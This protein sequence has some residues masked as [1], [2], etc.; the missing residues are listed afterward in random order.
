MPVIRGFSRWQ[1]YSAVCLYVSV[2][3]TAYAYGVYSNLL[4]LN[5][6]FSQ[7][8]LD[9]VASVGNTGLYLSLIAGLILDNFGLQAVVCGGGFLI[10]IGFVYIW[11]AVE[12]LVPADIYSISIFFF[13]SQFGVCC[14]VSSSVTFAVRLFPSESR[15]VSVGLTKGYYGLSSAVLGDFA[16]GYFGNAPTSFL[17]FIAIFIPT[18]G[19]CSS[20]F[21][22]LLPAH[23]VN[24][25]KEEY[26]SLAP[27]IAHWAFLFITLLTIGLLQFLLVLPDFVTSIT[28]VALTCTIFAVCLLPSLYGPRIV[29]FSSTPPLKIPP[30]AAEHGGDTSDNFHREGGESDAV[31]TCF[32]GEGIP[33][34]KAVFVWR[35]WAMYAIFFVL[36]GV[37]LMVI[38]N[39]NAIAVSA[40]KY[41]S[42]FFVT[43]IA[44]ANGLG[45]VTAGFIS[46]IAVNYISK[47]ELLSVVALA[48]AVTQGLHSMGSATLLYPC[49]LTVGFLFGCTVSLMAVNIADIFG[50]S[51]IATNFGAIDSAAMVGTLVFAAGIV[52]VYYEES[53]GD[54][55]YATSA[56]YETNCFRVPFIINSVCCL[57]AFCICLLVARSTKWR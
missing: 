44:L 22:N 27:F 21:A 29:S 47:L 33:L 26:T 17:L 35:F 28:A 23:A 3:G 19:A 1:S 2:V 36:T 16:G 46:D 14:F 32:Y 43:L 48:M 30:V 20:Q 9:I 7:N 15:G 24:F 13:L 38:Y 45:R 5:L 6:G 8:G 11:A 54:D 25:H 42:T 51:Y 53:D 34:A 39:I 40:G 12:G 50:S 52:N 18:I 37:G 56:C 49:L 57:A 41:P 55:D 10:F 31:R 4:K